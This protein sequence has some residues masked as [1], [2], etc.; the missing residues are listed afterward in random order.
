MPRNTNW[1]ASGMIG[2]PV[3][4]GAGDHLGKIDE[5]VIDPPSGCV[6]F[7]ILSFE[8][9]LGMGDRQIAV[10]W[11]AIRVLPDRD[12][13]LLDMDKN[14]LQRAP[15][16]EGTQFPDFTDP[17]ARARIYMHYGYPDPAAMPVRPMVVPGE[18][19]PARKEMSVTAVLVLILLICGLAGLTYM[20]TTKG[21]EQTKTELRHSAEG[22][23]YAMKETSGDAALTAKVKTALSLNK[24]V[25]AGNINVDSKDGLVTLRGEVNDEETRVIAGMIAQDTPGVREVRNHLY[26]MQPG[27]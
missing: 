23:T 21:W 6:A 13:V 3:R 11:N 19:R 15:S 4:N 24:R 9:V 10:P 7:A 1:A 22:V 12:Y 26:V 17:A 16:F 20:I 14:V 18:H 8:G 27:K 2:R 25:P 5:L